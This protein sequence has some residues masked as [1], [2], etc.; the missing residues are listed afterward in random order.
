MTFQRLATQLRARKRRQHV[1][2]MA[3]KDAV[4]SWR[5]LEPTSASWTV[6]H[7]RARRGR[8]SFTSKTA[9]G[10]GRIFQS[11]TQPQPTQRDYYYFIYFS[12]LG[13]L[14][15]PELEL[16]LASVGRPGHKPPNAKWGFLLHKASAHS[17]S[18]ARWHG[19]PPRSVFTLLP[20]QWKA[21]LSAA[22]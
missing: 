13:D 11:Q 4:T 5:R 7:L 3:R 8:R 16:T 2:V 17:V 9:A 1:L 18:S 12:S 20:P 22:V 15:S 6:T 21:S 14:N 10:W 19:N